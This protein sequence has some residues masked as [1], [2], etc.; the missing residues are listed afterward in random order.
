MSAACKTIDYIQLYPLLVLLR[1]LFNCIFV[2]WGR[3]QQGMLL[4]DIYNNNITHL[5][6]TFCDLNP[7]TTLSTHSLEYYTG[8]SVENTKSLILLGFRVLAIAFMQYWRSAKMSLALLQWFI[9][10]WYLG[11]LY[12]S[13][14]VFL[15]GWFLLCRSEGKGPV[16]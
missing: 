4:I 3:T 1:L 13:W 14:L 8:S 9:G 6:F 12:Y 15:P 11:T 16:F 2:S 10:L 5:I 7:S